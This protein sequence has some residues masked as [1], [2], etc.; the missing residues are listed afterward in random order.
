LYEE[1]SELNNRVVALG[2]R[3]E[4]SERASSKSSGKTFEGRDEMNLVEC[5][6]SAVANRFLDGR[7]TVVFQ[8]QT[9]DPVRR[10][11]VKRE[12]AISGSD[13]YGLPTS[14]DEDVL[15]ACVQ[16][17][18]LQDFREREVHFSRYELLKLLR[19]PDEGKSYKRL[20]VS[21]RRWKGVT[22]Y[23]DRAFYDHKRQSWVTRDFGVFDN[24]SI[25]EREVVERS[26]APASS[27]LVWNEVF[28]DN[29]QAGYLKKLDWDFY[30]RL[31]DPVAKRL[32]RLL[33]KRFYNSG[34]VVF[35]LREL[36]VR[37]VRLS[38]SYDSA[39]IKRALTNGIRE[40]EAVWD[41]H[42]LPP[43]KRFR[44]LNCGE[45]EVVF[46]RKRVKQSAERTKATDAPSV[47]ELV[48]RGVSKP[49]ARQL[50]S[51][52]KP[53]A[54]R[55][56]IALFDSYAA[57]KQTRGVG[58]LVDAIR[59]PDKY[60]VPS[61]NR[62]GDPGRSQNRAPRSCN[63]LKRELSDESEARPRE[64]ENVR[65]RAFSS[66]WESLT[67]VD[68]ES[69]ELAA[70]AATTP[71]KRDGYHRLREI[72]GPGFDHYRRI[73]LCDQ[74]ERVKIGPESESK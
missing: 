65:W 23:S 12:L 13:R 61:G 69:F 60:Q 66:F 52:H 62:T 4:E 14:K 27:W 7:K 22:V 64:D 3:K 32:Y 70:L 16:L 53:E 58:F 68:R 51:G 48:N 36:A 47:T 17:S 42:P 55:S 73:V 35:D 41:L 67:D 1:L 43:E 57:R 74:F 59:N 6:L 30:C 21:L 44:K 37:K 71:T 72:G 46:S 15:L 40:L 33:D 50:V 63:G 38:D 24:L 28:F 56:A 39:Q 34:E 26:A 18:A 10:A 11:F 25:Y 8:D 49:V 9:W 19:W 20:A 54:V 2:M 29:F 45:W 5:P 31:E